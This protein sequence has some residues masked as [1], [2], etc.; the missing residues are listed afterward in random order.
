MDGPNRRR[1]GTKKDKPKVECE[2]CGRV[3]VGIKIHL[4]KSK[5]GKVVSNPHRITSK[6]E[7]D[8]TLE[9]HQNGA[10][11]H[12][13]RS[14][15][16]RQ[17]LIKPLPSSQEKVLRVENQMQP[18]QN[19][20]K[21][22][23]NQA[24]KNKELKTDQPEESGRKGNQQQTLQQCVGKKY[25][26]KNPEV[27]GEKKQYKYADMRLGKTQSGRK[28]QSIKKN[29]WKPAQNKKKFETERRTIQR[30][31][32]QRTNVIRKIS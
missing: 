32:E 10:D 1:L 28:Q 25:K 29:G 9:S 6:S 7:G 21:A 19:H 12:E 17:S 5:C 18:S 8:S 30:L 26:G 14:T 13:E 4:A 27:V 16:E 2:V 15:K 24:A 20:Y 22:E 23:Q 31:L 3:F 11:D